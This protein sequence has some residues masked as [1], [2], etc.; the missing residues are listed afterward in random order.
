[1]D[2]VETFGNRKK[3]HIKISLDSES[4]AVTD[5]FSQIHLQH[6]PLPEINFSVIQIRSKVFGHSLNSP[7]FVSSMTLC[8][9]G[10]GDLNQRMASACAQVGW[11]MGVGSQRRQLFDPGAAKECE[12]LRKS[13]PELILF[14]NIGLSQVIVEAPEKIQ[15]LVDSLGAQ[16]L[17][18]HL[19]PLQEAIQREGTPQFA[20]GRKALEV[21]C[22]QLSVQVVLKETGC[23]FS[24]TSLES[25]KNMKLGAV[26]VSGLGGTHWGRIEGLREDSESSAYRTAKTFGFWG[27]STVESRLAARET[28][29]KFETW[30]SGGIRSGLDSAKALALGAGKVG[31]AKPVSY[32]HL[33]LPTKA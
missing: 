7:H 15:S 21:L 29:L 19:N 33:T 23:G 1:M 20:G 26:D 11:M 32:T 27:Q 6:N 24:K 8:H 3:D 25:I 4:Q 14:G 18:V 31:F 13:F 10:A 30:A 28:Q 12:Q 2:T 17:V 9:S 22:D 16:F 5:Q